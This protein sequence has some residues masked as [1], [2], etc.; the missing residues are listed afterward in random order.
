MIEQQP[1]SFLE[2]QRLDVAHGLL[3]QQRLSHASEAQLGEFFNGGVIQH[4]AGPPGLLVVVRSAQVVVIDLG[5]FRG[6]RW[7]GFAIQIVLQDR[8]DVLVGVGAERQRTPQAASRRFSPKRLPSRMRPRQLRK[9]CSGCMRAAMMCS[10][11]AA[12]EGPALPAQR[13]SRCGVHSA[14]AR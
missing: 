11:S 10:T 14:W 7:Q 8:L 3:V 1:E 9:P 2:A 6:A 4:G 12:V 13:T 5:R